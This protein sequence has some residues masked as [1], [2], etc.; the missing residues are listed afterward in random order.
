MGL[1]N[2][3]KSAHMALGL[4]PEILD[5]VDVVVAVS[6]QLR[7]V[8]TEVVEVRYIQHVIAAPAVGIDNGIRHHL[9][10]Y[11]RDQCR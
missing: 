5:T 8:D 10:L 4:V 6:K 2:T 7:M 1:G 11:N 3:V 9:T